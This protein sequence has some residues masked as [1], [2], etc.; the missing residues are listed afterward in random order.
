MPIGSSHPNCSI[1]NCTS[2]GNP[3]VTWMGMEV[4]TCF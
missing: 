2:I 4:G 1:V 3:A